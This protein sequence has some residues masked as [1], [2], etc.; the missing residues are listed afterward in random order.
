M[1][2][3]FEGLK[4]ADKI[5][6]LEV[7]AMKSLVTLILA[8]LLI[9]SVAYAQ[10]SAMKTEAG[11]YTVTASFDRTPPLT[12]ANT[13]FITI[14]DAAGNV[15]TDASVEVHYYMTEKAGPNRKYVEMASMGARTDAAAKNAGYKANLN[16]SMSGPWN[17]EVTINRGGQEQTADFFTL[18]K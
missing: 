12:G 6:N 8:V 3:F 11:D 5:M 2:C 7:L 16:F 14:R 18:I 15:I 1:R 13:F 4:N 10:G 17:I 9:G